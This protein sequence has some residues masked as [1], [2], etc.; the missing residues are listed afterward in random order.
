[1]TGSKRTGLPGVAVS[2][3]L[4]MAFLPATID[5]H[6]V[7]RLVQYPFDFKLTTVMPITP[8]Q[9]PVRRGR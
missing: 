5:G 6:P 7:E 2:Y 9:V 1:M 4:D 3:V 8:F